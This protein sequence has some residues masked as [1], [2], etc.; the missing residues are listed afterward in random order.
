MDFIAKK[1][2]T[3]KGK[4]KKCAHLCVCLLLV[5]GYLKSGS[6]HS[7]GNL[8]YHNPDFG[9][10]LCSSVGLCR[11]LVTALDSQGHTWL[12]VISGSLKKVSALP[13]RGCDRSI[14]HR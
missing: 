2:V 14:S 8:I 11:I 12:L 9:P 13:T 1:T 10:R 7:E 3:Q 4:K 5:F 6:P